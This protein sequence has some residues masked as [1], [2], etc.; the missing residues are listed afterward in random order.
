MKSKIVL[1]LLGNTEGY[2]V[3]ILTRRDLFQ[4]QNFEMI[5]YSGTNMNRNLLIVHVNLS[6]YSFEKK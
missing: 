4:V 2:F 3:I 1:I 5:P 6:S